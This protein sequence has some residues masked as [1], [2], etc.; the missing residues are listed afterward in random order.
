MLLIMLK[1]LYNS[2]CLN[3][4]YLTGKQQPNMVGFI[5]TCNQ[6][7]YKLNVGYIFYSPVKQYQRI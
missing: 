4:N 3:L 7:P 5:K 1:N 6:Y 2:A